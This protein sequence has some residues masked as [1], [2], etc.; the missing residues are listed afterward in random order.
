MVQILFHQ[1]SAM[2][3][4]NLAMEALMFLGIILH[5]TRL[6]NGDGRAKDGFLDP[7]HHTESSMGM[8]Q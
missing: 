1:L 8:A 3:R 5:A 4:L 2:T 6:M 7:L